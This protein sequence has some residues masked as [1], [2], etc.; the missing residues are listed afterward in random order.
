MIKCL[1]TEF[2]SGY[3]WNKNKNIFNPLVRT[4]FFNKTLKNRGV[5]YFD[6]FNVKYLQKL[7]LENCFNKDNF[8]KFKENVKKNNRYFLTPD[9]SANK[10]LK[11]LNNA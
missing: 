4:D 11:I 5:L 3:Q 10:F 8:K 2:L 6:R 9:E 7:I 1:N